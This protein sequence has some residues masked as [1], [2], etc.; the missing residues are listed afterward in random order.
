MRAHRKRETQSDLLAAHDQLKEAIVQCADI[1]PP[2]R[3]PKTP[4]LH[5]IVLVSTYKTP[6]CLM[7]KFC[8]IDILLGPA[9]NGSA[10]PANTCA[11][12]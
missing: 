12:S 11:A 5:P 7:A 2:C 9:V 8:G 1:A 6:Q 4:R 3:P 10:P